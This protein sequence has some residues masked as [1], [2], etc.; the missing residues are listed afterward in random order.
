MR[1]GYV[2]VYTGHGKGK[3]TA[4]LGLALR[5]AGAGLRVLICQFMKKGEYSEHRALRR[6][7]DLVSVRQYGRGRFVCGTPDAADIAAARKGLAEAAS[8]IRSG[9][10]DLVILDEVNV[11]VHYGLI[12]PEDL[13]GLIR[14][15][16]KALEL[17]L[18]GRHAHE[19]IMEEADLVTEMRE[20]KHYYGQGVRARRGIEK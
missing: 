5:A 6:L 18:T 15:K 7:D 4:S 12:S 3:T 9:S 8:M 13:L 16:P 19:R 10:Y 11:A 1:R 17:V 14:E 2:Q 20:V